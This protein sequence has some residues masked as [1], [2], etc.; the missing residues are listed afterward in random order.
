MLQSAIPK[1]VEQALIPS[2]APIRDLRFRRLLGKDWETLPACV[3]RRFSIKAAPGEAIVYVGRVTEARAGRIGKTLATLCR[4]I[5]GPLPTTFKTGTPS[6]VSITEDCAEGGQT[7]T[8]LYGRAAGF[9]Q[10]IH[11]AK[12]FGGPTG[13]EEHVGAGVGMTLNVAVDKGAL[14]FRSDRYFISALG[15]RLYLPGWLTPGDLAVRHVP[16]DERRFMFSLE[17]SHWLFGSILEQ[18]VLFEE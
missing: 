1:R 8:R 12:R 11:S 14:V 15:R 13:L 4:L 10:V 6:V 18:S 2:E 5:G 16:I 7:W 9:P 17:I 3:R